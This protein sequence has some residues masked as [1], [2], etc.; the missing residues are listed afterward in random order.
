MK[1]HLELL[2]LRQRGYV[3][4]IVFI[5]DYKC[6]WET[7]WTNPGARFGERWPASH[8]TISTHGEAISGLDFRCLLGLRVSI[9]AIDKRRGEA[10]FLK[11][12]ACGAKTVAVGA[13]DWS[14]V[15]HKDVEK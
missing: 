2:K 1:G 14:E 11:A 15:F 7:E 8:C 5:N 9:S 10:L 13:G 4:H 6:S 3:P 12:K